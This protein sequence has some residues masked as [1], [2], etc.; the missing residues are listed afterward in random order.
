MQSN[1]WAGSKKLDWHKTFWDLQ[2]DKALDKFSSS[3]AFI[4]DSRG[5]LAAEFFKLSS[6]RIPK[7]YQSHLLSRSKLFKNLCAF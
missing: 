7:E 5:N 4:K 1:F 6:S 2:K 3:L